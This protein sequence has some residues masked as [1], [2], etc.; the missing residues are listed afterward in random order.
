[1]RSVAALSTHALEGRPT[2]GY[3]PGPQLA[4][5]FLSSMEDE[6]MLCHGEG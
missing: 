6:G 3:E 5:H 4:L 2:L 1:M